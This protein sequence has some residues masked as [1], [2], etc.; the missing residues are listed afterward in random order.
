MDKARA[1]ATDLLIKITRKGAYSGS[2]LDKALFGG[3]FDERDKAFVTELVYGTLNRL[4]SIDTIIAAYSKVKPGKMEDVVL[5][6]LRL[7]VYQLKYLDKVPQYAA[8][9]EAVT[10][11]RK[12]SSK[13]APFVNGVLRS[14]MRDAVPLGFK[15]EIAELA[16]EYSMPPWIT[17]LIKV[18]YPADYRIILANLVES[19]G[20][21][22][23]VNQLKISP[24]DYK[25]LLRETGVDFTEGTASPAFIRL[26]RS[27]G[28]RNLPGFAEGFF[29]VQN[30]SAG[31][32]ALAL[33][34]VPGSLFL[35]LCAAP[36]GKSAFLAE[37]KGAG[38]HIKAFDIHDH[39][40][41][42]MDRNFLRLGIKNIAAE[43]SD[44]TVQ[45]PAFIGKAHGVI[46]DV[47]CSGLGIV[48]SK[49]DIKLNLKPGDVPKIT[50]LQRQILDNA[51]DY[52]ADGGVLLYSTCTL[53]KA[54][55]EDN[56]RDFLK[57][58]PGFELIP[59]PWLDEPR[60]YLIRIEDQMVTIL[61]GN[62][63]DGFFM[64]LLHKK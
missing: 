6:S 54:E 2:E 42:L 30:E 61:P 9:N 51:A 21:T 63:Y 3:T 19:P 1:L 10:I 22:I 59:I 5:A 18:Q 32:A 64:A 62:G 50:R 14:I 60:D 8:V 11:V 13:A 36:G 49:P 41:G 15:D 25:T 56:V 52:T 26:V 24:E 28:V 37:L 38:V 17:E 12:G 33:K 53:N 43:L 29:S 20:F 47:P 16:Y 48:G 55:N 44:A 31:L 45:N 34:D 7:A 46:V 40:I 58:H 57:T 23:R 35:D 4:Y 27:G 39:K